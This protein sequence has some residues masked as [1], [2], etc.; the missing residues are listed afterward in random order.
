MPYDGDDG[1]ASRGGAE[2]GNRDVSELVVRPSPSPSPR[3]GAMKDLAPGWQIRCTHCD[4]S[5][6]AS[7]AGVIRIGAKSI[8][9]R[10]LGWCSRCRSMRFLAIEVKPEMKPRVVAE[11][12]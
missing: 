1:K 4:Q 5:C 7:E 2:R 12:S 9:K 6:D 10:T 8:G 3:E 11:P